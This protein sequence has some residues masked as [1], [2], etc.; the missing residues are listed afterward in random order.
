MMKDR[1]ERERIKLLNEQLQKANEQ[2]HEFAQEKEFNGRDEREK[3]PGQEKSMIR[4]DI[5]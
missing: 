1:R 3:S 5:F 4:W 2:L